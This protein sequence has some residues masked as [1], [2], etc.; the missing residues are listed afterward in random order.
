MN[1]AFKALSDPTRR[2][3]LELLK[4]KDMTAGE[5]AEQFKISKPSISHHLNALKSSDLVLW[6]KDGQNIIYSLNT[7]VLQEIMKWTFDF[8]ENRREQNE[9]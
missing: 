3:I 9:K 1:Q 8:L 7:T 5:I 4:E 6:E 2:K